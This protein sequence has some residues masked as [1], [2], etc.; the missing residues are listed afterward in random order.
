MCVSANCCFKL[1]YVCIVLGVF[2]RYARC[3]IANFLLKEE[4][5][6]ES[7]RE[8]IT[9]LIVLPMV[10]EMEGLYVSS[11]TSKKECSIFN[12]P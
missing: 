2:T 5:L 1:V 10:E 6:R 9:K 8:L 4:D 7:L 3:K 12:Q 11:V